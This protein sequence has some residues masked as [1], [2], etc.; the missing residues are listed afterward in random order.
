MRKSKSILLL[1][2]TSGLFFALVLTH[3]NSLLGALLGY[4]TG[5]LYSQWLY[6]DTQGSAELDVPAAIRRLR[7]SFFARLGF[8][9]LVVAVVGRYQKSWLFN[10]A[11]GLAL[12]LLVS[13]FVG[14]KEF[15][16]A[17]RG[18]L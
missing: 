16:R 9:T 7:R 5:F 14:I 8:V 6:K 15:L 11:I 17:E 3:K 13:L 4:W 1:L 18:E 12:G 10:L 2:G